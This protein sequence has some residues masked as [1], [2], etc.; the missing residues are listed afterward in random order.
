MSLLLQAFWQVLLL[1][2]SPQIIPHSTL[3]LD[4]VLLLHLVM[5]TISAALF[6]PF[7]EALLV[8][9]L[10]TLLIA[11]LSHLLLT[12]Y[13][14]THRSV[15]VI[16][17]IAGCELVL[18]I[19]SLPLYFWILS[20]SKAEAAI[21][22]LLYIVLLGWNIAMVAHIYRH[23]LQ[24]SKLLGFLYAIGYMSIYFFVTSLI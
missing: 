19:V 24:V 15:Q 14:L 6:I 17:A 7:D 3:L 10:D 12:L 2:R 21:P 22:M 20:V 18:G 13:G 23:A 9:A 16:T 8:A 1:R 5:G 11:A 4:V